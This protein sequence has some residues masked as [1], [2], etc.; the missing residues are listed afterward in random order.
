[1]RTGDYWQGVENRRDL[2]ARVSAADEVAVGDVNAGVV[3]GVNAHP[4]VH[5]GG[6]QD[7]H[8]ASL[9]QKHAG[10]ATRDEGGGKRKDRR[11]ERG[12]FGEEKKGKNEVY[13]RP[14]YRERGQNVWGGEGGVFT[15]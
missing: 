1:M 7:R 9:M 5:K 15:V 11:G 6:S 14:H 10:E 12:A 4:V 8:V 3:L 2:L 13:D